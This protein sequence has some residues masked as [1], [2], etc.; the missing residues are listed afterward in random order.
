MSLDKSLNRTP[1]L[2][3]AGLVVWP[4]VKWLQT[5]LTGVTTPGPYAND[6]AAKAAGVPINGQYYQASGAVVVRLT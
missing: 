4:W 5:V 6:A 1:F 3:S 2:D